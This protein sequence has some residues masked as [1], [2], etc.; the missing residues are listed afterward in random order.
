ML[1]LND[2]VIH[3]LRLGVAAFAVEAVPEELDSLGACRG[4]RVIKQE[5]LLLQFCVLRFGSN[6]DG[7]VGVGVFPKGEEICIRGTGF[8]G[9]TLQG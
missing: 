5:W 7:D 6:E 3:N 9:I 8:G 4:C 2:L 1:I